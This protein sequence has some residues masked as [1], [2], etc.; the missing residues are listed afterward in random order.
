MILQLS[1]DGF[2][3]A[4]RGDVSLWVGLLQLATIAPWWRNR[5]GMTHLVGV[6]PADAMVSCALVDVI[7]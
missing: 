7:T 1:F 3:T 6:P 2:A 5:A 4:D